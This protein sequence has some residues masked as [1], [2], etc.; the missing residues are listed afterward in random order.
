MAPKWLTAGRRLSLQCPRLDTIVSLNVNIEHM[1]LNK[2]LP[3]APLIAKLEALGP[4]D[5]D[6]KTALFNL[7]HATREI[8]RHAV[9]LREGDQPASI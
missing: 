8:D 9:V 1:D 4:L 6:A 3:A 5:A 2:L 7:P